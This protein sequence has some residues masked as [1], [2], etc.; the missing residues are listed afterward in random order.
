MKNCDAFGS[1]ERQKTLAGGQKSLPL[2]FP[3]CRRLLLERQHSFGNFAEGHALEST[4][5]CLA[6]L[7]CIAQ[8][9]VVERIREFSLELHIWCLGGGSLVG[10]IDAIKL[11]LL[12]LKEHL[13]LH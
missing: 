12:L 11:A 13:L 8:Q 3:A 1:V 6:R 5:T 10:T 4:R 9:P 7:V 2:P